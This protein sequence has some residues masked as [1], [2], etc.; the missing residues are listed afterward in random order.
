MA[1]RSQIITPTTWPCSLHENEHRNIS[2]QLPSSMRASDQVSVQV[3]PAGPLHPATFTLGNDFARQPDGTSLR[4]YGITNEIG[5]ECALT[6]GPYTVQ[7]VDASGR[8]LVEAGFT[9]G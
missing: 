9:R 7:V 4:D 8:V 5:N 6:P 1:G 3:V 2:V